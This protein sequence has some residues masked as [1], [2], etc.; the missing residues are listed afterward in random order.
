M[1]DIT[2]EFA[3]IFSA[4]D[5]ATPN[6][7][8]A[9]AVLDDAVPVM[10]EH[11]GDIAGT[12]E[13]VT[14]QAG[15]A[16]A[17][18]ATSTT[19]AMLDVQ[20]YLDSFGDDVG[21]LDEVFEEPDAT[22]FMDHLQSLGEAAL[23]FK[24]DVEAAALED[25]LGEVEMP[26]VEV[27]EEPAE[28]LTAM[29]E[30]LRDL[31]KATPL[32]GSAFDGFSK[33]DSVLG[34]MPDKMA[35]F[36]DTV[37]EAAKGMIGLN[38]EGGGPLGAL[39][40][41]LM[42]VKNIGADFGK[43]ITQ[44]AEEEFPNTIKVAQS[45]F[46]IL[47]K[48]F[49]SVTKGADLLKAGV[50]KASATFDSL[51]RSLENSNFM[52]AKFG[53]GLMKGLGASFGKGGLTAFLLGPIGPLLTL[54]QPL[55]DIF[56]RT[57]QPAFEIMGGVLENVF[58]P[59]AS[60]LSTIF[61]NMAPV[62]ER[63]MFPL[64][65]MIE[66]VVMLVADPLQDALEGAGGILGPIIDAIGSMVPLVQKVFA[67]LL[68]I[69][70]KILPIVM[71]LV[72]TLL[73]IV[74][75][76]VEIFVDLFLTRVEV[77]ADIIQEIMPDLVGLLGELLPILMPLVKA[78][79]EINKAIIKALAPFIKIVLK[80][81][82]G[83]LRAV[84]PILKPIIEAI[85]WLA[86]KVTLFFEALEIGGKKLYETFVKPFESAYDMVIG[87]FTGIWESFKSIFSPNPGL[88]VK[89]LNKLIDWIDGAVDGVINFFVS[90]IPNAIAGF[91]DWIVRKGQD[92][93]LWI[94]GIGEAIYNFLGLD[95]IGEAAEGIVNTILSALQAPI[96]AM[97]GLINYWVI[98]LANDIL[99]WDPPVI[100]GGTI[101]NILW[102]A[103]YHIPEL[104][105]GGV[106]TDE[107][108][109]AIAEAGVPE[110]VVPLTAEAVRTFVSPVMDRMSLEGVDELVA[111]AN[112][113]LEVLQ[114]PLR[115]LDATPPKP[116]GGT[117][118][119]ADL[120]DAV[121]AGGFVW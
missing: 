52:G 16:A 15:E 14:A 5:L 113:I 78:F 10:Q 118:R 69:V 13:E 67:T 54:L 75:Q 55:I 108:T 9:Q 63:I 1:A 64:V 61:D 47:S 101:S 77:F 48:G 58:A 85:V 31:I 11:I 121:G 111:T 62:I 59:I 82:I 8:R 80:I 56:T 103:E 107:T 117:D 112:R 98:D 102:G 49:S 83:L 119:Y 36:R 39:Q 99:E 4:E 90:I 93:L 97:K 96:E 26:E 41:N 109:A 66:E 87:L 38:R 60:Q 27:P 20:D 81:A 34:T 12:V 91:F 45:A 32:L 65:E 73:P 116:D 57:L 43:A 3:F 37:F 19:T 120:N 22:P 44:I 30:A 84:L 42:A 53:A 7:E 105:A 100:P 51:A 114:N 104:A 29:V 95:S 21:M 25:L 89:T 92:F 76:L 6:I 110:A 23:G 88:I 86:D 106:V 74:M 35:S 18:A 71:D 46:S 115:V 17:S 40:H 94:A 33:F 28:N 2:Q 72:E 70:E 79:A 50:G 24:D 68:P